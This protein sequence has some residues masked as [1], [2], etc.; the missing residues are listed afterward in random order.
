MASQQAWDDFNT[1]RSQMDYCEGLISTCVKNELAKVQAEA[2]AIMADPVRVAAVTA[3]ADQHHKWTA[4]AIIAY[5][6]RLMTLQSYLVAQ[7][8]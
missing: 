2:E 8:F 1:L 5:Y 3:L 7:G 6:N 4:A